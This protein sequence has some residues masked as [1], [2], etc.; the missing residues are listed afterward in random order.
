VEFYDN[1]TIPNHIAAGY[2]LFGSNTQIN[3]LVPSAV[4]NSIGAGNIKVGYGTTSAPAY[5]SYYPITYVATDPGIFTVNSAGAGQGAILNYD[6]TANSA[7]NPVN[8]GGKTTS[9]QVVHIYLTGLGVPNSTG[10]I[11]TA[12]PST[13]ASPGSCVAITGTNGFLAAANTYYGLN[14]S[15]AWTSLDGAVINNAVLNNGKANNHLAPC[16]T[17]EPTVMIGGVAATVTYAGWVAGA[18]A[19]LYQIDAQ[20]SSKVSLTSPPNALP[21]VVT[22]G[23]KNGVSSQVGVTVEVTN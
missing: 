18:V 10:S 2:L 15:S 4:A 14:A 3:V 7:T 8:I 6:W 17:P 5:S 21:V 12:G 13:L 19:G 9:Q 16:L 11:N 20:V 1:A 22:I 23:T